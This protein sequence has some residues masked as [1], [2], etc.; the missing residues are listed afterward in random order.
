[1]GTVLVAGPNLPNNGEGEQ[2]SFQGR[3]ARSWDR[4]KGHKR[5]RKRCDAHTPGRG[6]RPPAPGEGRKGHLPGTGHVSISATMV[7]PGGG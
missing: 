1:M 6:G 7:V 3:P 5:T 4:N 2:V